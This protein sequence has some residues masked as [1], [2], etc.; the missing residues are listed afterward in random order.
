MKRG[1]DTWLTYSNVKRWEVLPTYKREATYDLLINNIRYIHA[2]L[3]TNSI[4]KAAIYS[5]QHSGILHLTRVFEA[6]SEDLGLLR[7]QNI[8]L[9]PTCALCVH[10]SLCKSSLDQGLSSLLFTQFS[11]HI[12]LQKLWQKL[13][14]IAFSPGNQLRNGCTSPGWYDKRTTAWK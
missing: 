5:S 9:Q 12:Q 1:I 8:H 14:H 6:S 3:I 13:W 4:P 2:I 10:P 11:S 7:P